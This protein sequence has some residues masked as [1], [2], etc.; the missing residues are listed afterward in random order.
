MSQREPLSRLKGRLHYARGG[1]SLLASW[2]SFYVII[3]S[4]AATLTGLMFVATT[5]AKL[6]TFVMVVSYFSCRVW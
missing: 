2:Q 6:N 5:L 3:G 1:A 4:A